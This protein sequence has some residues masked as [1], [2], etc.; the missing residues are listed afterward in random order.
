[1][2][3]RSKTKKTRDYYD[4]LGL[5][6]DCTESDI[7]KAYRKT[8]I[9]NHPDKHMQDSPEGKLKAEENFKEINKAYEILSD[10]EKRKRYNQFGEDDFKG[11]N[12]YQFNQ[13]SNV[14]NSF[15]QN[16]GN[17]FNQ[18]SDS[19]FENFSGSDFSQFSNSDFKQFSGFPN[20]QRFHMKF[21]NRHNGKSHGI[22]NEM[23][24]GMFHGMP[25]GMPH[26]MFQGMS[27]GMFDESS[28]FT[29]SDD[30]IIT[31]DD[32]IF[33]D[34]NLT[35]EEMYNGCSKKMKIS[36]TIYTDQKPKK[37]NEIITID[38]QSGWKAGTKITF[39]N[40]GDVYFNREP[41]DMT[42][43]VKQ[44]PHNVFTRDGNDL[45]TTIKINA[46]DIQTG[47]KREITGIDNEKLS[48]NIPKNVIKDSDY[49][50][51]IPKKGMH[52]RKAGKI[53]G[54][55][56]IVIKFLIKFDK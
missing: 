54:R 25:H 43:V 21:N 24:Q 31:K 11:A 7:K 2:T 52:I 6:R 16:F 36:R 14:F 37:E 47:F 28:D 30:S 35:L 53:T 38:V 42:F 22:P 33:I 3:D 40:K 4:I 18:F 51:R 56:D 20:G 55:G 13:A 46:L 12:E 19:G 50:H 1:M 5:N 48:I 34:L 23:P 39:H 27:N 32:P 9:E 17:E 41:A 8:A 45:I 49:M 29:D 15:F 44:K 26:G 10:P